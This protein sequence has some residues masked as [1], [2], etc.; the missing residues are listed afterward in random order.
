MSAAD[1]PPPRRGGVW[2][3]AVAL[4]S[5]TAIGAGS[6]LYVFHKVSQA[7]GAALEGGRQ[8]LTDL[9]KV[10]EAF[11]TSTV[12]TSFLSYAT[13]VSGVSRLQFAELQQVEVFERT[14][15]ASIFW[16]Q[17]D[18]PD[19]VVEA[20]APVTTTYYLDLDAEWEM[21]LTGD[22]IE[23]V[24]PEIRFNE[25]AVDASRIEYRVRAG[26]ILRDSE[27]AIERL[28]QGITWMARRRARENIP[29]VR[30]TGRR[31]TERFVAT[32]L[33]TRFEDGGDYTVRVRFRDE[34]PEP[35]RRI[36][37]PARE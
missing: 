27:T 25:P 19:L 3:L 24:A 8:V 21:R 9:R 35:Q 20:R 36:E 26:S 16:G 14:D 34:E 18:L 5:V 11:R 13:R 4:V 29:L 15:E 31:Q 6:L 10:A 7:P 23:V 33:A 12:T 32:W 2:P 17:L 28:R 22:R 30:E 37:L 1:T